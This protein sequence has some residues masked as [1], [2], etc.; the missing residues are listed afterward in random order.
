MEALQETMNSSRPLDKVAMEKARRRQVKLAK[1]LFR[2]LF[3]I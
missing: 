2:K 3:M 1:H